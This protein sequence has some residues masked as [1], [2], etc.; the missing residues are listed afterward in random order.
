V[1]HTSEC[2]TPTKSIKTYVFLAVL[3]VSKISKMIKVSF[4]GQFEGGER[5]ELIENEEEENIK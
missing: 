1:L 5:K 3:R 4:R 2:A